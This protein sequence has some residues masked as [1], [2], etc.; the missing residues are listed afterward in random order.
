MFADG[1]HGS[2]PPA[3]PGQPCPA[4]GHEHSRKL[5]HISPDLALDY[6]RCDACGHVWITFMDGRP[7]HHVTPLE[8][9]S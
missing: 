4:C 5:E 1:V 7:T 3:M 2:I 8:K 6:Y 9:T